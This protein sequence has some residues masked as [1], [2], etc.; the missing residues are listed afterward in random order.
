MMQDRENWKDA[1]PIGLNT[2]K[3]RS[4]GDKGVYVCAL[5]GLEE[6]KFVRVE[7]EEGRASFRPQ[8]SW[9]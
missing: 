1:T 8:N 6:H 5:E 2:V 9:E 3:N 4:G 7:I